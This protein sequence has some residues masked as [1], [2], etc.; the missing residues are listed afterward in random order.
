MSEQKDTPTRAVSVREADQLWERIGNVADE[1]KNHPCHQEDVLAGIRDEQK[2]ARGL[3]VKLLIGAISA[4]V[5]L[6]VPA[7]WWAS[8]MGAESSR[9]AKDVSAIQGHVSGLQQRVQ[10][11]EVGQGKIIERME[12][13]RQA[14]PA[15]EAER[16]D[17][18]RT[19]VRDA[20]G[21]SR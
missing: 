1:A 8:A 16:L 15:R 13:D 21:K 14:E 5:S 20:V 10:G 12:A 19:V 17:A 6:G 4:I 7:V 9:T 11:V 2:A 3:F 18:I